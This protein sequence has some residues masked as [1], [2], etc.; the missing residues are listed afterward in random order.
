MHGAHPVRLVVEDDYERN[1][2]TVF[3][4]LL[5]AIPHIIWFFLW[6]LLIVIA[7]IINWVI[8]IFTGQPPRGLHRLM[9]AYVRYQAHLGAYLALPTRDSW[10]R[11]GSTRSTCGSR[12]SRSRN[13]VGPS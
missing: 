1:R 9:C 3:F 12:R 4:R 13:G 8:S 2:M 7:S 10:G 11:R 6:T 5:L